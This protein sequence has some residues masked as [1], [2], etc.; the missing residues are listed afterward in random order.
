MQL[1]DYAKESYKNYKSE[2]KYF[3]AI[4][5]TLI[6]SEKITDVKQLTDKVRSCK[7]NS[8]SAEVGEDQVKSWIHS[9]GDDT[10]MTFGIKDG[11]TIT[12]HFT[13]LGHLVIAEY[14][15]DKTIEKHHS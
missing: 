6:H 14:R 12:H 7:D 1:S 10:L 4:I 5:C 13:E 11:K 15:N 9:F 3:D 2:T 8:M